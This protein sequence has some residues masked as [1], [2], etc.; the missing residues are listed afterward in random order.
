MA[1]EVKQD[2]KNLIN[3]EFTKF[4][5]GEMP[6]GPYFYPTGV[7]G[8]WFA[9]FFATKSQPYVA[10]QR[11]PNPTPLAPL[12]GDAITA[13]KAETIRPEGGLGFSFSR[14]GVQLTT[15]ERSRKE[16]YKKYEEMDDYPEVGTAFDI[17][18]DDS[19]Q[20]TLRGDLWKVSA[21]SKE[22]IDGVKKFLDNIKF[23]KYYWDIIRNTVKYGDCFIELVVDLNTPYLGVQ[24]IKILNPNYIIRV[25][26]EYGYLTDYLQEIPQI[27]DAIPYGQNAESMMAN[28]YVTLD[29]NQI[30]H[31]RQYTSDPLFYP[32]GKSIAA[33]ATKVFRSLKLM[34]DAMLIYRLSRAPE[35]RVFYID[36][37][38]MPTTKAEMFVERLK[39]KFKKE[40]FFDVRT[41]QID[42][43]YNPLSAD[44]D[45]FV[46]VRGAGGTK[47]ETLLGATNLDEVEDVRY[48]RDKLLA[49][50]KIPKD[51]IVEKD[52]SPERKANLSQLDAKF[53]RTVSRVQKNVELGIEAMVRQHMRMVGHSES[54]VKTIKIELP[55][56]SDVYTRRKLEVDQLKLM[57]VQ[58]V[59]GLGLFPKE[60]L[61]KEYF[62]LTDQEIEEVKEKLGAEA[63]EQMEQQ[64][65]MM[66]GPPGM[67]GPPDMGGGSPP[68]GPGTQNTA[69]PPEQT[70]EGGGQKVPE[71]IIH[72]RT[73]AILEENGIPNKKFFEALKNKILEDSDQE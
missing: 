21:D 23:R 71:E 9:K 5:V 28:K 50:L 31:F 14:S 72:N 20:K 12:A 48:F 34:E 17:Y 57:V 60:T 73:R 33:Q 16:R 27:R 10:T 26:N 32:Y 63:Q 7:F 4:G 49:C 58:G 40:K 41:G 53:A 35:R 61:Y 18:A 67:G 52:K 8:K 6:D 30:I 65:A 55:D 13:D 3:E 25:E 44:E 51:Y 24:R 39:E 54:V 22:T 46:P 2:N 38:N 64:M 70:P 36:V 11:D 42:A 15:V 29:K 1:D 66:G 62:D 19:T 45:F 59:L 43:K 69:I 47:I 37:A 56:P 68:M